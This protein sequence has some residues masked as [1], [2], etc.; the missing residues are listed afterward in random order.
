MLNQIV[1]ELQETRF[2]IHAKAGKDWFVTANSCIFQA[3][4]QGATYP[5][6]PKEG[7]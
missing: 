6:W 2:Y 3:I 5:D 4:L 7:G 1:S